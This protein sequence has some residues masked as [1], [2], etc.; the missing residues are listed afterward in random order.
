M[1][2]E[3]PEMDGFAATQ[4]IRAM[5][6][7]ERLPIVALTAHATDAVRARCLEVGMNDFVAKPPP[8]DTLRAVLARWIPS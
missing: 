4:S 1:D 2:C 5:G 3:M 7:R 8:M 6:G